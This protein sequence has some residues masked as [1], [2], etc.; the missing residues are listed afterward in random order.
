VLSEQARSDGRQP[1]RYRTRLADVENTGEMAM[2][3]SSG[4]PDREV[5]EII[6]DVQ[7]IASQTSRTDTVAA[8]SKLDLKLLTDLASENFDESLSAE[9][10]IANAHND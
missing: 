8:A 9:R 5:L 10:L 3:M 6:C 4:A 7:Q 1:R 2:S